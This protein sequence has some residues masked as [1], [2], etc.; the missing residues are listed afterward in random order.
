LVHEESATSDVEEE[1]DD[2]VLLDE[3]E[4]DLEVVLVVSVVLTLLVEVFLVEVE[5]VVVFLSA[6]AS[7]F[8][9]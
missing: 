4:P 9:S 8:P 3:T 5:E 2:N 6:L 1:D 7:N